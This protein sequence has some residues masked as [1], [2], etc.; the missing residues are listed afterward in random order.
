MQFILVH[1]VLFILE[2]QPYIKYR[3]MLM[4]LFFLQNYDETLELEPC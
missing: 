2:H 1:F 3:Y 4:N